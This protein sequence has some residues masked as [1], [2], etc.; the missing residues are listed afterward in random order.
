MAKAIVRRTRTTSK[1]FWQNQCAAFPISP[2]TS[3]EQESAISE[4]L[5]WKSVHTKKIPTPMRTRVLMVTAYAYVITR[6]R[7]LKIEP[8][9]LQNVI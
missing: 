8:I 2:L 5:R 4:L 1:P 7:T 9:K 3:A 6:G